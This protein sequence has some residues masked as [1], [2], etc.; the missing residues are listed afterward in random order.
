MY[1]TSGI[2]KGNVVRMEHHVRDACDRCGHPAISK[3]QVV[4]VSYLGAMQ[5]NAAAIMVHSQE[6]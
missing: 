6:S 4:M 1:Q 5:F 2:T 3:G